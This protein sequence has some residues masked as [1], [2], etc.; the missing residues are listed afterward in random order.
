MEA[1][2]VQKQLTE[3]GITNI[4]IDPPTISR[5]YRILAGPYST[6][7]EM[8]YLMDTIKSLGY[9]DALQ[10]TMDIP[11]SQAQTWK[12][13]L[14]KSLYRQ[15]LEETTR[16]LQG[17]AAGL[18]ALGTVRW[19]GTAGNTDAVKT[20]EAVPYFTEIIKVYPNT[21][22][23]RLSRA[24]MGRILSGVYFRAK[25]SGTLSESMRKN[26]LEASVDVLNEYVTLYPKAVDIPDVLK[27][28]ADNQ[29]AL[30]GY[31][32]NKLRKTADSYQ[33]V[34]NQYSSSSVAPYAQLEYAGVL[35]ELAVS[36]QYNW[37]SVRIELGKVISNYPQCEKR[38]RSRALAMIAESYYTHNDMA[39]MSLNAKRVLQEYPD[40]FPDVMLAKYLI[41]RG[42]LA[43]KDYENAR[44]SF[45]EVFSQGTTSKNPDPLV[46]I[47]CGSATFALAWVYHDIG[48]T[49]RFQMKIEELQTNYPKAQEL[50]AAKNL[51]GDVLKPPASWVN[52]PFPSTA[53][54]MISWRKDNE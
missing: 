3:S 16:S 11:V 35:F 32:N 51:W 6:K 10:V 12:L 24:H 43:K 46:K 53:H 41:G 5:W 25:K 21:E 2:D 29:H 19:L 36:K 27:Q 4:Q 1:E 15:Y 50:I 37:D 38:L 45:E 20:L 31:Y 52:I 54:T 22:Q 23:A 44:A 34:L 7:S 40:V 39:N 47:L 26:Y 8:T 18:Y 33:K 13:P 30:S 17:P 28:I 9:S 48:D 49:T 14:T 42:Y